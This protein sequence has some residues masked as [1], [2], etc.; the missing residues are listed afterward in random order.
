MSVT[1]KPTIAM[2]QAA[3]RET[4]SEMNARDAT[5]TLAVITASVVFSLFP[6]P[7]FAAMVLFVYFRV[8]K[9]F[10]IPSGGRSP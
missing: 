5:T 9:L 6:D 10:V 3:S 2:K 4:C 7:L 8:R 1:A